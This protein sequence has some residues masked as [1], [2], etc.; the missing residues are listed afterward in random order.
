MAKVFVVN[1]GTHDYSDAR[2]FG[3]LV[4]M[5]EGAI[6]KYEVNSI[7]RQFDPYL[8]AS[9]PEDFILQTG[10]SIMFSVAAVMYALL[11]EQLNTLIWKPSRGGGPGRYTER[12]MDFSTWRKQCRKEL[13][14]TVVG[15]CK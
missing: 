7:F 4:F 13:V 2:R 15:N 10:P 12:R 5:S 8:S 1:K 3:E 14:L 6:N 11:H 9:T